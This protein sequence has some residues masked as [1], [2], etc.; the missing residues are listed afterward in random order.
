MLAVFIKEFSSFFS[1]LVA[2]IAIGIF[3]VMTGLFLWV[4]PESAILENGYATLTGLF[5]V[6]PFLFM[7]LIPAI[8]MRSLAEERKDG[9]FELLVTSPLSDT[10]IIGGKFLACMGVVVF[11]LLLTIVYYFTVRT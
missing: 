10:Q 1:S 7:F 5:D 11:T 9:T 4:F 8:T 2:Y 3:L 6:V